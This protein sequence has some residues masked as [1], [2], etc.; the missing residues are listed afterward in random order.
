[1]ST[2]PA[3]QFVEPPPLVTLTG[4]KFEYQKINNCGPATLAVNMSYY[5][6]QGNQDDIAAFLKPGEKDKNVR[7]DELVHYVKT[8][9]GWLDATFRV[10]GAGDIVKGF[11]AN[12]YPLI[13][14]KGFLG[15]GGR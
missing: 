1:M 10:G 3:F 12:G 5:G 9:A 2:A 11:V 15:R 6:W 4:T 14:E 7:W 13:A 8:E